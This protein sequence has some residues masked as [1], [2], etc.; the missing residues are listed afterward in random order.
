MGVLF[1]IFIKIFNVYLSGMSKILVYFEKYLGI[2]VVSWKYDIKFGD[3]VVIKKIMV[4]YLELVGSDM[5]DFV[6][7]YKCDKDVVLWKLFW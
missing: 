2:K 4:E 1:S 6:F 3:V 5:I 7:V